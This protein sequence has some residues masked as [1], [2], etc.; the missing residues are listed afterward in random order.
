MSPSRAPPG[1][2]VLRMRDTMDAISSAQGHKY[3]REKN[4]L[5]QLLSMPHVQVSY[6]F[7]VFNSFEELT[8]V[9]LLLFYNINIFYQYLVHK[10]LY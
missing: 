5:L 4:E 10:I 1:D 8:T 9:L 2:A 7:I 3:N 6:N